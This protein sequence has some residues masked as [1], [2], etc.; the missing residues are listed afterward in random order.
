MLHKFYPVLPDI[1]WLERLVPLGVKTVQL[2]LKDAETPEIRRQIA[3]G[4]ELCAAHDCQLIVNDYWREAIALG[5]DYIHLGQ[6]D[7]AGADVAAI[8]AA[9]MKLGISTHS[10]EELEIALKAEPD[11]VA[12]G[13]VYETKLKKMKWAPQGL[14][15][16]SEW[17]SLISCPLV[18]IAGITVERA[19]GV[20]AAGADS[21]AVVTDVIAHR[22]PEARVREWLE[23]VA[24]AD[25]YL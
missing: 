12:L 7:L 9:G 15:R 17:K 6:E 24:A 20:L 1:S 5:A 23:V 19:P 18:A 16:V 10:H 25:A 2:R 21:L 4:L 11:Y 13:P 8:R 14:T 22:D 3:A